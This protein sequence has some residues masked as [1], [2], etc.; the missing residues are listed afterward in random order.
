MSVNTERQALRQEQS[1]FHSRV[2]L[3]PCERQAAAQVRLRHGL[4][5][6]PVVQSNKV[7]QKRV[8]AYSSKYKPAFPA[9]SSKMPTRMGLP[10]CCHCSARAGPSNR[11]D[12]WCPRTPTNINSWMRCSCHDEASNELERTCKTFSLVYDDSQAAQCGPVVATEINHHPICVILN[13]GGGIEAGVCAGRHTRV[14]NAQHALFRSLLQHSRTIA[15]HNT[16]RSM[17]CDW[18]KAHRPKIFGNGFHCSRFPCTRRLLE[19]L[20]VTRWLRL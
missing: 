13:C 1:T 20:I 8:T 19:V 6:V 18:L 17:S 10:G 7:K 16:Q 3:W 14:R 9:I 12:S 15:C 4:R 2:D 5:Q 11:A